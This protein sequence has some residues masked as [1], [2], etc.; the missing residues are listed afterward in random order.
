MRAKSGGVGSEPSLFLKQYNRNPLRRNVVP[1]AL[2]P[3][4]LF[5]SHFN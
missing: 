5:G 1:L 2:I 3:T 4:L